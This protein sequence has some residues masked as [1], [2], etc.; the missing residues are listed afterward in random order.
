MNPNYTA[1]EQ[2]LTNRGIPYDKIDDYLNTTDSDINS[3]LD[4]NNMEA[5]VKMLFKHIK[6]NSNILIQVD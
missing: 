4:L 3:F 1:T 2:I 6:Q 5:A